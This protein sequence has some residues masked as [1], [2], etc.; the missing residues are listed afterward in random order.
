[1]ENTKKVLATVDGKE[2]TKE[3]LSAIIEKYPPNQKMYFETEEGM[4]QLLEQ[5]IAF[6]LLK[7]KGF[8]MGIDKRK[9]YIAQM[10]LIVEQLMTKFV[11]DDIF[12]GIEV[13]EE[14]AMEFYNA[15]KEGFADK[16]SVSAKHILVNTEEEANKI[17]NEITENG[18]SFEDA[19]KKYSSCPSNTAGGD[20]GKFGRGM[21][22]KEFE[23][24]A[25]ELP[26]NEVSDAVKTQFGYHLI[27]VYEKTEAKTKAFEDVKDEVIKNVKTAKYEAKYKEVM[28]ELKSKHNVKVF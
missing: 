13:S 24:A 26:L 9:E 27:K 17:K 18:L 1:M 6:M 3:S 16:E 5:K 21:M 2:I 15:H 22:V 12:A 4:K 19:A 28:E 11:M 8:E 23:N 25:F 10:D 20:L 7:D 14:E